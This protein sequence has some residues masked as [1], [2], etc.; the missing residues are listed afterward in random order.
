MTVP[1][2]VLE[3]FSAATGLSRDTVRETFGE[4]ST[5]LGGRMSNMQQRM[6]GL[7]TQANSSG[8]DGLGA[9]IE[10]TDGEL[11][12]SDKSKLFGALGLGF[13]G[14]FLLAGAA[15]QIVVIMVA[16]VLLA[17]AGLLLKSLLT[18]LID[19]ATAAI[20]LF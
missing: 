2:T 4:I 9:V 5:A 13:F 10:Y 17:G 8:G 7:L 11:K 16:L 1:A 15:G 20:D 18:D 12:P 3:S 19:R 14:G 6:A